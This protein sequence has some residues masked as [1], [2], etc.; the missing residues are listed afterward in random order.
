M[1]KKNTLKI[2]AIA[3]FFAVIMQTSYTFADEPTITVPAD[4]IEEITSTGGATITFSVTAADTDLNLIIPVCTPSSDSLFAL[5]TT[6]VT[7]TATSAINEASTT[8]ATFNV[9]VVD[10]TPPETARIAIR[11]GNTLVGPFTVM[12]PALNVSPFL[13]SPTG[14]TTSYQISARSVL[15]QLSTLD[16][17]QTEF[18]ITDIQYFSSFNSF[19]VNCISVPSASATPNCF[20]WTYAVNGFSPFFGMDGYILQ[21]GDIVYVFFGSQWRVS[22]DKATLL[23]SEP[24][25]VTAQKYDPSSGTYALV[26]GEVVGAVQF[27]S[28]FIA[29][30]FATS[31]T[32]MNGQ[33]TFF[34]SDA[35][36]YDIGIA[37][38]G[39]FPNTSVIIS[40][41]PPPVLGGE[42]GGGGTGV[43]THYNIDTDKA[44]RF[45]ATHQKSNGSFGADLY[46]D[47]AAIALATGQSGESKDKIT[48]Y[49]KSAPNTGVSATDYERRAMA[50]MS[51]GI[52]PYSGTD[53]DYIKKITDKFDGIQIGEFSLVND[54]IFAIFPLIK[55]GHAEND[56]IIQKIIA[57]I[58]SK[59]HL[60]GSWEGSVDLT[61]AAIQSLALA[62]SLSGVL[63]ARTKA[64]SYLL[65]NQQSDGGFGNSSFGTSWVM[66]AIVVLEETPSNW[67]KNNS[68]P[69]DFL[70]FFQQDDGGVE[71]TT[72]DENTRIWAT[73][74]AIPAGLNKPW[75]SI[76]SSFARPSST[77][78]V[79][80]NGS[81][82]SDIKKTTATSLLSESLDFLELST[83]TAT[84][85]Q[86]IS[87]QTTNSKIS[88]VSKNNLQKDVIKQKNQITVTKPQAVVRQQASVFTAFNEKSIN[89][90]L[91]V[92]KTKS[93]TIL[94]FIKE[95][96]YGMFYLY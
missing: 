13:L 83:S 65:N 31:T 80:G 72:S 68:T 28:N 42:G 60:N 96:L 88:A 19:I 79:T 58:L 40:V 75:A 35:G 86:E 2:I 41:P 43:I 52:N 27:D 25:I 47:W 66:Q 3:M 56:A 11:D 39:Y 81:I 95:I 1:N 76:L 67:Q 16:A 54:D 46:T 6:T 7:C 51:L 8:R 57:F 14:T 32:D 20:N 61:A 82:P 21:N 10:T 77:L 5:G 53:T 94:S 36:S 48:A 70:H 59:Q 33:A 23:T 29:T 71:P 9:S 91:R 93:I 49:L 55:S 63:E 50:L 18:D 84:T 24:L 15:A 85:T 37:V 30:E 73:A 69:G 74:Y 45:L 4:I 78:G 44:F 87:L 38:S 92:F 12:L 26:S 17:T 22:T 90:I 89:G 64:K 34:I 62:P